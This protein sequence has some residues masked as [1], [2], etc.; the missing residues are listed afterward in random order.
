[1]VEHVPAGEEQHCD[2]A[3]ACPEVSVLQDGGDVW[4]CDSDGCDSTEDAR[5]SAYNPDPV[6]GS[7]E[8]G[9][10]YVCGE[11]AGYPGV[12]VLGGLWS[13]VYELQAPCVLLSTLTYPLVKSKRAGCA[14][15]FALGPTVG[16]K[17][18]STGAV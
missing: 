9:F 16:G 18:R 2:Q 6:D 12:D 5:C 1:M 11:V 3:Q 4:S 13:M 10:R 15:A 8:A 7:N 14:S 17:N